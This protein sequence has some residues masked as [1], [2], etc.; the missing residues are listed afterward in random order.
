ML[1]KMT[2]TNHLNE[3]IVF[4]E[5]PYFAN[6]SDLRDYSW[7]YTEANNR[8]L[9]FNRKIRKYKLPVVIMCKT[10]EEGFQKRNALFEIVE[11]DV[12][13][14]Q[15]GT[16]QIGDYKLQCYVRESAKGDFL[17]NKKHMVVDLSIVTDRPYWTKEKTYVFNTA[18]LV[19][20]ETKPDGHL[21]FSYDFPYDFTDSF[22]TM[23]FS[24]GNF[25]QT[26]FK[27]TIYG[28]CTNP[29]VLI[30]GHA[31]GVNTTVEAGQVLVIDSI[32]KTVQLITS[33]GEVVNKFSLRNKESYIFEKIPAGDC[34]IGRSENFRFDLTL[35][36]ERSEPKWT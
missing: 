5:F 30:N 2:Y 25:V 31:Y 33:K 28:A 22:S 4:G 21:D 19:G 14:G 32:E 15:Y 12:L 9:A 8:I 34:S 18:G 3:K 1:D 24:N 23:G 10:E 20:E 17:Y 16:L 35:I 11:K 26:S 7:N 36:E 6:Y 29:Q 27:I 13:A